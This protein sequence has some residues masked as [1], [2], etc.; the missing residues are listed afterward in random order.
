MIPPPTTIRAGMIDSVRNLEVDRLIR[1][2][3][4]LRLQYTGAGSADF[5]PFPYGPHGFTGAGPLVNA[6]LMI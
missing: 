2:F 5:S 4:S 1:I 6:V 3:P